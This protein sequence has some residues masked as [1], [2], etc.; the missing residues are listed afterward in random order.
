MTATIAITTANSMR[1]TPLFPR[2]ICITPLLTQ[3][4]APVYKYSLHYKI[5]D[6]SPFLL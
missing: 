1:V 6:F 4:F 3:K 2:C 5:I